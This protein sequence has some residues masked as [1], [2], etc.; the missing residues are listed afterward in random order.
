MLAKQQSRIGAVGARNLLEEE[1]LKLEIAQT[2]GA[3]NH[4]RSAANRR[5]ANA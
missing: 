2:V 1:K 5:N 3:Q 4:C